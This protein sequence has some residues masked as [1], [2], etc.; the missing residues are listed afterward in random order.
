MDFHVPE[1]VSSSTDSGVSSGHQSC[2]DKRCGSHV[3]GYYLLFPVDMN[4]FFEDF[5]LE[6]MVELLHS[7]G[8]DL[9]HDVD[10]L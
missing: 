4:T 7:S 8:E 1:S 9:E 5:T 2:I 3:G 10:A 6:K